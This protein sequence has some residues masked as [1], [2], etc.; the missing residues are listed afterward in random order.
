MFDY[1]EESQKRAQQVREEREKK[2]PRKMKTPKKMAVVD[3]VQCTGCQ[4]CVQFCPVDCIEL[5]PGER[6]P[7]MNQLVEIDLDRCIG[8]KKCV[9][10]CPWDT[11][12][13]VEKEVVFDTANEWT[14]RSVLHPEAKEEKY[15]PDPEEAA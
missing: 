14:I 11:I 2:D 5:T 7:D 12:H 10:P 3:Q 8:C 9:D 6:F 4:A 13:M 1:S 15:W